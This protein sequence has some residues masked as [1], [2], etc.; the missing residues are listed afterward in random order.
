MSLLPQLSA[1]ANITMR[2]SMLNDQN[3]APHLTL[4][5]VETITTKQPKHL[6]KFKP[7]LIKGAVVVQ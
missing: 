6:A 7:S 1:H 4:S 3:S 5:V 2:N